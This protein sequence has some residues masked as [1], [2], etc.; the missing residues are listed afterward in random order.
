MFSSSKPSEFPA[1]RDL[2]AKNRPV[3][4]YVLCMAYAL[5]GV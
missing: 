1:S 2:A 3:L 5:A 4:V